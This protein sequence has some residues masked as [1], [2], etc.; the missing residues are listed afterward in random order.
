MEGTAPPL[1]LNEL[2]VSVVEHDA[3]QFDQAGQPLTQPTHR[4]EEGEES[5]EDSDDQ[6]VTEQSSESDDDDQESGANPS[7]DHIGDLKLQ[8]LKA[9]AEELEIPTS[10]IVGNKSEKQTWIDAIKAF[11]AEP[12]DVEFAEKGGATY[13]DGKFVAAD[14]MRDASDL[15][16]IVGRKSRF[17]GTRHFKKSD[18]FETVEAGSRKSSRIC[19][20]LPLRCCVSRSR[21]R[22]PH[23]SRRGQFV[24]HTGPKM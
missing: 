6:V 10:G 24:R 5:D 11:L 2:D 19:L 9:W 15:D 17:Y 3:N 18:I 20:G 14:W 23:T 1:S 22:W 8:G 4:S 12:Q 13:K 7:L 21:K 16:Q